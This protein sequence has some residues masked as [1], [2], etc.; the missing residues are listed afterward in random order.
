MQILLEVPYII[1]NLYI[2]EVYNY[3]YNYNNCNNMYK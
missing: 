2:V 1:K 3:N